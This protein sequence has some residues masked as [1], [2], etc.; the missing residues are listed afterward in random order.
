MF[1]F[2]IIETIM[3]YMCMCITL[4][5]VKDYIFR[6]NLRLIIAPVLYSILMVL[7]YLVAKD[8]TNFISFFIKLLIFFNN[9]IKEKEGEFYEKSNK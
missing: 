8:A 2:T 5:N 9:I 7:N 4:H 6:G 1:V 3:Y